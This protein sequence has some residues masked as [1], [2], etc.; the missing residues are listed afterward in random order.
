MTYRSVQLVNR[1]L[2]KFQYKL[3]SLQ[4]KDYR[5]S[6]LF[7]YN[8]IFNYK[9]NPSKYTFDFLII[10]SRFWDV[11]SS[12]CTDNLE[13]YNAM[14]GDTEVYKHVSVTNAM[15]WCDL[16]E[17][18]T[19]ELEGPGHILL[20]PL[21]NMVQPYPDRFESEQ[22]V[23]INSMSKT[24]GPSDAYWPSWCFLFLVT[25]NEETTTWAQN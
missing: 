5:S 9:S 13:T 6:T 12:W 20:V 7:I 15:C 8:N 25:F 16:N 19:K 18:K 22:F 14:Q 21:M 10:S 17:W 24:W 3:L 2:I 4:P 11:K 23:C 1:I